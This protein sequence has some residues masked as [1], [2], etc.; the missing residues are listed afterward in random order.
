[1][2]GVMDIDDPAR[3]LTEADRAGAVSV[4]RRAAEDGRLTPDE[5]DRRLQRVRE[6]LVLGQLKDVLSG[7]ESVRDDSRLWPTE[8]QGVPPRPRPRPVVHA[9]PSLPNPPGYRADDRLTIGGGTSDD[10]RKGV[11]SIPP[12]L[13]LLPRLGSIKLDCRAAE[14]ESEVIDVEVGIGVGSIVL[15][16]P[17]GWAVDADRLGRGIGSVTVKVPSRGVPGSPT[18][19]LHGSVGVGSVTARH[20]NWF[21]RRR[22]PRA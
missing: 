13:R 7:L 4:L 10:N 9:P 5:L 15:V 12:F 2:L 6:A 22:D 3:L 8:P 21:E 1:M 16:L 14:P 19:F 18:L 11:W 20:A 17:E